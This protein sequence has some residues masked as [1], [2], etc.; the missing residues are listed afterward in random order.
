M[1][2]T[3]AEAPRCLNLTSLAAFEMAAGFLGTAR[4]HLLNAARCGATGQCA[5]PRLCRAANAAAPPPFPAV[6]TLPAPRAA[7]AAPRVGAEAV[8]V[9][10]RPPGAASQVDG[11]GNCVERRALSL[12]RLGAGHRRLPLL[13]DYWREL[14]MLSRGA[15]TD[16]DPVRLV[17]MEA[18]GWVHLVDVGADD[19]ANF[20]ILIRGWRVPNAGIARSREG[21]RIGEHPIRPLAEGLA[22]D[23]RAARESEWPLYHGIRSRLG[24]HDYAYRRLILPFSVDG[25]RIDRLLVATDFAPQGGGMGT[26]TSENA[27]I[28]RGDQPPDL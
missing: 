22:A 17:Q 6:V 11:A 26:E 24:G 16:F 8:I 28:D 2:N 21:M 27:R 23:Y 4:E 10:L 3:R 12:D 7:V 13:F 5:S 25:K 1:L 9:P 14:W 15:M 20:S 19:P 18:L